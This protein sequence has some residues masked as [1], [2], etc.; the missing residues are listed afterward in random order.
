VAGPERKTKQ[1]SASS[2]KGDA[3]IALVHRRV[4]EMRFRWQAAGATEVGIDGHVELFDP[5]T[6]D[7]LS[8]WLLLQSKAYTAFPGE[9]ASGFHFVCDEADV[10]YWC[11][12]PVPVILVCSHPETGNAWWRHVQ[13]VFRSDSARKTRRVDFDKQRDRFN[14]AAASALIDLGLT[15]APKGWA[16]TVH[17]QERLVTN[18]LTV[19]RLAPVFYGAP[20]SARTPRQAIAR[21]VAAGCPGGDWVLHNNM[22]FSFR[23]PNEPVSPL[24]VL[25]DDAAEVF[26]TSEWSDTKDPDV[27]RRFVRLLKGTM[28]DMFAHD[29]AWFR[30]GGYY[31]FRGFDLTEDRRIV[32][33]KGPGRIVFTSRVI[34]GADGPFVVYHR[35]HAL[36]CHFQRLDGHWYLALDPTYHYSF[37]GYQRCRK[38]GEWVKK[39]KALERNGA[40]R[41]SVTFWAK[42][43]RQ[44][45]D[46]MLDHPDPR[47]GFGTL[48]GLSVNRGVDDKAWEEAR[49]D[50]SNAAAG[51]LDRST[52]ELRLFDDKE[53][54]S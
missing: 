20:T 37:D 31:F 4:N 16:P 10:E 38:S 7:A 48:V 2:R 25:A 24:G 14:P 40:V 17:R 39:M 30:K 53:E 6:G 45:D 8:A 41:G 21:L 32:T 3:G 52:K 51:E 5:G 43:L 47:L 54:A 15:A 49:A 22:V 12:Q 33:G 23:G 46:G 50:A 35:H 9:T 29:L 27:Q 34:A 28:R 1:F 11:R 13:D 18:L 44:P 26:D 42:Y 19:T 36:R